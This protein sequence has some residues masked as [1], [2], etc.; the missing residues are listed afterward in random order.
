MDEVQD[1][2]SG[3]KNRV[4]DVTNLTVL[5]DNCCSMR[6]KLTDVF[7][8]NITIKLDLFHAVQRI[9]A[10]SLNDTPIFIYVSVT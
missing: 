1:L 3:V 8:P 6:G 4:Q 9:S 10:K 7:G 5:L 2:L